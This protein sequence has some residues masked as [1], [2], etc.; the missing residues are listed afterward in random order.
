MSSSQHIHVLGIGNLGKLVAHSI[1]K[2]HPKTPITLLFHRPTLAEEWATAGQCIEIVRDGVPDRQNGFNYESVSADGQQQGSVIENLVVATKSYTTVDALKPFK[3]RLIP[4]STLLFLQNGIGTIDEVNSALFNHPSQRP[5]YL[6][7]IV[8]HG[9]YAT[10]KFSSVHAG[11]AN[12]ILGPVLD[13][14]STAQTPQQEE[15]TAFLT[16]QILDAPDL[17]ASLVSPTELL[18]TQLQKLTVNAVINPLTVIFD[19]FNGQL[20]QS[21]QICKL[22]RAL[23]SELSGVICAIVAS[24]QAASNATAAERAAAQARFSAANLNTIVFDVGAKTAKNISS[25]RQDVLAGRKTEID[26]ING[27]IVAQAAQYGIEC[28][29]NEKIVELV[30]SITLVSEDKI[31]TVFD[32]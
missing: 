27:Y 13:S 25:M 11:F 30:R 8:N 9:V 12:T 1:R 3:D 26:Y 32:I 16:R 15:Q 7:G 28:P 21:E 29:L 4:S 31:P 6:A 17:A 24:R 18:Q 10:S 19:C 5:N 20:F 22:I 23:V 2:S 14:S